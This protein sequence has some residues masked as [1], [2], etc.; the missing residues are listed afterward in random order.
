MVSLSPIIGTVLSL[1]LKNMN[2]TFKRPTHGLTRFWNSGY[3][4]WKLLEEV[5]GFRHQ[6][7]GHCYCLMS[8]GISAEIGMH[9]PFRADEGP[10]ILEHYITMLAS[11][12]CTALCEF[13]RLLASKSLKIQLC[14]AWRHILLCFYRILY[15]SGATAMAECSTYPAI[16]WSGIWYT[17]T[18]ILNVA[19]ITDRY[20]ISNS[21]KVGVSRTNPM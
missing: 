13:Q 6:V 8:H 1:H 9:P 14:S 10:G 19:V 15:F 3:S 12:L 7:L 21:T 11:Y 17:P 2:F 4:V 5:L 20:I 18:S 16:F